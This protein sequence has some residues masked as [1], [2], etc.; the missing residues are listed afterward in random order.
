M[1]GVALMNIDLSCIAVSTEKRSI[2]SSSKEDRK[3]LAG[4]TKK[5][6]HQIK[7]LQTR[8]TLYRQRNAKHREHVL[9]LMQ[10]NRMMAEIV[11]SYADREATLLATLRTVHQAFEPTTEIETVDL[12]ET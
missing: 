10:A 4:E 2:E 8:L 1:K 7:E 6:Q 5:L 12:D 9:A 3:A 11:K